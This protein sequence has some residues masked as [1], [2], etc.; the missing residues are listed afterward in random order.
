MHDVASIAEKSVRMLDGLQVS[1]FILDKDWKFLYVNDQTLTT[2]HMTEDEV[3]KHSYWTLFPQ[4]TGT[5]LQK[6]F[7][8]AA[9]TGEKR[10]VE[11]FYAPM[12]KHYEVD[13]VPLDGMYVIYASTKHNMPSVDRMVRRMVDALE[14]ELVTR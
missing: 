11:Y 8:E 14:A 2:V 5:E 1:V 12:G 10:N 6:N 7:F 13:I 4:L 9:K 3:L